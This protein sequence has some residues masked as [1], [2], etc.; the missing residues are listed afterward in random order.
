LDE[1]ES[2]QP[3]REV[4][5]GRA[6]GISL[7]ALA[8]AAGVGWMAGRQ[9]RSPA[10]IAAGTLPPTPSLI[11]VPVENRKLTADV[12]T[13]GSVGFGTPTEVSLPAS[14]L[15]QSTGIVT[16]P[17]VKGAVLAEGSVALAVS[18]RPVF[19]FQGAT[20]AYRDLALKA[21][22]DDVRQLEAALGRLGMD[23]GPQDGLFDARTLKA[24]GALYAKAG[25]GVLS[26]AIPADE[27]LFFPN[28]PVRIEESKVK[29]GESPSGPVMSVTGSKLTVTGELPADDA[30]LVSQGAAVVIEDTDSGVRVDGAVAAVASTPGTNGVDPQRFYLEIEPKALPP[31]LAGATVVLT[32]VVQSTEGEVLAVPLAALATAADGTTRIEVQVPEGPTR[33]VSVRPGL[34]AKGLVAVA[35]LEG[36]LAAGDLVVIGIGPTSRSGSVATTTTIPASASTTINAP[37]TIIATTPSSIPGGPSAP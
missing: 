22:G 4:N 32:I 21:A 37:T 11:T 6:V 33:F 35:P 29:A 13:R 30:K 26:N 34:V 25:Y 15:K 10:E 14:T 27:L 2:P 19:I 18:A 8:L 9:V 28:I 3:G 36:A 7:V 12:V 5:R 31:S 1:D 24:V 23:P 17:P 20:P 16:V